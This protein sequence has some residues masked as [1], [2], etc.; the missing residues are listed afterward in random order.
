MLDTA[1]FLMYTTWRLWKERNHRVFD[2]KH[3]SSSSTGAW[4]AP[5]RHQAVTTCVWNG[6][7][8]GERYLVFFLC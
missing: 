2:N 8:R 4:T 3:A 1:N 7:A 6:G 5:R